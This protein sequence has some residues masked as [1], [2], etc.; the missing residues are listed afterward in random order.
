MFDK[1]GNSSSVDELDGLSV[2][3]LL[4]R[5][6]IACTNTTLRVHIQ[7]AWLATMTA[8]VR[9]RSRCGCMRMCAYVCMRVCFVH[10]WYFID[11]R[12]TKMFIISQYV[13]YASYFN[14]N[15]ANCLMSVPCGVFGTG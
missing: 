5:G 12:G 8:K 10:L 3:K 14:Y 13:Q 4:S 1:T 2:S 7:T 9:H 11:Y 6:Q 15:F